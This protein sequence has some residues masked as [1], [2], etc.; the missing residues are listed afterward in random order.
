MATQDIIIF[1]PNSSEETDALIAFGKALKLKFKI[2]ESEEFVNNQG[3]Q[4]P[5]AHKA[6]VAERLEDYRK[7]PHTN[8]NFDELLKDIREKYNL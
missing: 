2:A 7:N 1:E 5:E 6:I 8:L 4:I 3:I